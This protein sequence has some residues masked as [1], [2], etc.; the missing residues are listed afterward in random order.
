MKSYIEKKIIIYVETYP[1]D[2]VLGAKVRAF[3]NN[4]KDKES[5]I[6]KKQYKWWKD[7]DD[8]EL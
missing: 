2:S 6:S 8:G 3:V 1:N 4:Q 7:I 5:Y